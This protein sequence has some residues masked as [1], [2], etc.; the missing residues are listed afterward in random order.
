VGSEVEPD[1]LKAL[2]IES[3]N[4]ARRWLKDYLK[5]M[6]LE[7]AVRILAVP[8]V[9]GPTRRLDVNDAVRLRT[10]NSKESLRV[11]RASAY[12]HIVRL[13]DNA[14]SITPILLQLED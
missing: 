7:E 4:V 10:Q 1:C 6:V 9:G 5:L 11:H 3:L 13:L 12:F 14:A 8:A 2:E